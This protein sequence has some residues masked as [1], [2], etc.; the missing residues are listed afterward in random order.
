[1][2]A[3]IRTRIV[4]TTTAVLCLAL[5]LGAAVLAAGTWWAERAA[6]DAGLRSV[7]ADVATLVEENRLPVVL[8][9]SGA[10]YVQVVDGEG[11]VVSAS[12]S[13]D[14]LTALVSREEIVEAREAP[15]E[16]PASRIAESGRLRV[17][18]LAA[19]P[20][21]RQRTVVVAVP[22]E[23]ASQT[24]RGLWLGLAIGVP[25]LLLVSGWLLARAV[26]AALA[27]VER[28]R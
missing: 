17:L 15:I 28:L 22:V 7:A 8:P 18:A 26:G 23:P 16:V 14:R 25:L 2:S 5:L 4:G 1:M 3:G 21:S 20:E 19:G 10:R 13:A 12:A 11:A 27:P 24:Q 9:V 6:V